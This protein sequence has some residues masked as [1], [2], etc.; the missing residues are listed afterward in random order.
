[1]HISYADSTTSLAEIYKY[2]GDDE[3]VIAEY[4]RDP[5][6]FRL[7]LSKMMQLEQKVEHIDKKMKRGENPS[8]FEFL[9][10]QNEL[11][12]L[13]QAVFSNFLFLSFKP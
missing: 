2:D 1:M 12:T 3:R 10:I 8:E 9:S 5:K 13:K 4:L 11:T 6:T 7:L